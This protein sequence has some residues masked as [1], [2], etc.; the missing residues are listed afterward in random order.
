MMWLFIGLAVVS[1]LLL[2]VMLLRYL[3]RSQHARQIHKLIRDLSRDSLADILVPDSVDGEVWID[4]LLLTDGGLLV[5]DIR[6]YTGNLFGGESINEWTQLIGVKSHKFN[7]PLLEL[8][9]R[10][11]AVQALAGD[12]PVTGQVVFTRRGHFPKGLPE[13]VCMVDEVY[14]RLSGFLRPALPESRL[15]EAWSVVSAAVCRR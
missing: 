8:P 9:A 14:E 2:V 15:D 13:G 4:Y 10:I 11:Q 3:R 6:D 12:I 5:L 1:V 7:N